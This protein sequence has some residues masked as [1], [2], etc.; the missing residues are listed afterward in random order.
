MLS[1]AA[2]H[3]RT[4]ARQVMGPGS[5]ENDPVYGEKWLE[6]SVK[7]DPDLSS[8]KT[9][10]CLWEEDLPES[11]VTLPKWGM[12]RAGVCWEQTT[13]ERRIEEKGSGF[14]QTPRASDH[15][16][17]VNPAVAM[18]AVNRQGRPTNLPEQ[19]VLVNAK[20][21]PT[22][23]ARDWKD[24]GPNLNLYRS[25]RQNQQLGVRVKRPNPSGGSLNPTWVE[26]RMGWPIGWTDSKPLETDKYQQWRRSHGV[27]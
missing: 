16:G 2:S 22:P 17:A 13:P 10:R 20:M 26:G 9:H 25:E 1:A 8:W 4:S 19:A 23:T 14:W 12:M 27:S 21:W 5:M 7:Y 11:S 15:E 6:L 24:S 3:A 18:G